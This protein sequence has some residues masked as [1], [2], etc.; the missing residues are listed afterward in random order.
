M[1]C[2]IVSIAPAAVDVHPE[3]AAEVRVFH[4][5]SLHP[6]EFH[7]WRRAPWLLAAVDIAAV[8][9]ALSAARLLRN[10]LAEWW[11]ALRVHA[12]GE[13]AR[14]GLLLL[15]LAFYL[16]GLYPG[17][18]LGPVERLRRRVM[19]VVLVFGGLFSW[20][21]VVNHGGWSRGIMLLTFAFTLA[22]SALLE[23]GV[24]SL[25]IRLRRWGTP[26]AILSAGNAGTALARSLQQRPELGLV[27][28]ALFKNASELWGTAVAGVPVL[29]PPCIAGSLMGRVNI[30]VVAMFGLK[31][32][33]LSKIVESL[34]FCRVIVVPELTGLQSLWVNA[35]D[36]SGSLGLEMRR[37]LLLKRNYYLK[38]AADY[39]LGLPL[40]LVSAPV[41]ALMALWIKRVSPGPAFYTQQR[42][43]RHGKLVRIWKLRTMYLDADQALERY[44]ASNAEARAHWHKFFKLPSDPRVL[45]GIGHLLR[46]TSLDELPQLW[47]VLRGE[48]SLVGPR[49]FPRYHMESFGDRFRRLRGSALPGITGFWQISE[50]SDGDLKVQERLDTYY[51]RNW[52]P[53]LDAY[54]LAR[55]VV[56]VLSCRG[57]Y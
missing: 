30:A 15:P 51:I 18:G 53:W 24:V 52:S 13:G 26:A 46:R 47:N 49:P 55:T 2:N 31:S 40:F 42:E 23:A 16:A 9:T 39:A 35:R 48:M 25:L 54:I 32:S 36:L 17:Y 8:Q 10:A 50:R 7:E 11:P 33:E 22:L 41:I 4:G 44:L 27:P 3:R 12:P 45:P 56:A 57:A 6:L 28:V 5:P 14:A 1:A 21:N 20:D 43:G 29:G 37:N 38:R 34:P 19:T